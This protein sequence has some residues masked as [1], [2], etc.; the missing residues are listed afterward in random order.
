MKTSAARRTSKSA[1][2]P[3][4]PVAAKEIRFYRAN[5]KPYG[6]FSNLFRRSIEFDGRVFP[7]AEHAYQAGKARKEEVKEWILSAPTPG[8]VAMAAHGL[9]TWDI[10]ANWSQIKYERMR[11]VLRAKFAQHDDLRQLLLSTGNARIVEAGRVANVVNCTWGEVNGKGKNMLGV[12]LMEL[13]T[14]L[15]KTSAP[16]ST[17][18]NGAYRRNGLAVG[19]N[20]ISATAL[21]RGAAAT[22]L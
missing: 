22:T 11:Q 13:R 14:E 19:A 16:P 2:V 12:L 15:V 8:L 4:R 21:R 7:T 18:A 1:A 5:E 6:A 3:N 17:K 9:Y 10:V 20:K